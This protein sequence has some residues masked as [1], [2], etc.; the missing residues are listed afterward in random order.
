MSTFLRIAAAV[1]FIVLGGFLVYTAC[2]CIDRMLT[3]DC[4]L[5][6]M[7]GVALFVTFALIFGPLVG[8]WPIS[9]RRDPLIPQ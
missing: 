7:A 9:D 2:G 1:A 5:V 8:V 3:P 4:D 6:R